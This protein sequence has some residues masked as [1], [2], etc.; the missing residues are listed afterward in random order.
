MIN[1]IAVIREKLTKYPQTIYQETAQSI[2][3][4]TETENGFDV[5]LSVDNDKFTVYFNGWHE[6]FEDEETAL[7]C[8]AFGLSNYCR[9]KEFSKNGKPYKWILEYKEDGE[10]LADST[11]GLINAALVKFWTRETVR[12]LRN[13]LIK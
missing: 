9:L 6:H 10:W 12:Y 8:F 4:P 2:T 7:N 11:T 1:A 13:D 3:I 5:T